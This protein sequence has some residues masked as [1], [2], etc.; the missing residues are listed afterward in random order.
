MAR[1]ALN[2]PEAAFDYVQA[3]MAAHTVSLVD[4]GASDGV[5]PGCGQELGRRGWRALRGP[6]EADEFSQL[7]ELA[8]ALMPQATE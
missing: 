2:K 8:A 1:I 6:G 5:V 3:P 7:Q 4:F